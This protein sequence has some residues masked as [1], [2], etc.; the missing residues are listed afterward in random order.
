LSNPKN[1]LRINVG[2]FINQPN[3][4]YREIEFELPGIKLAADL[5]SGVIYGTVR[6]SRNSEGLLLQGD[7]QTQVNAECVRCL[8]DFSQ[9]L[10]TQFAELFYFH[11]PLYYHEQ[12]SDEDSDLIVPEDGYI[13]LAPLVREYLLLEY[14]INPLCRPDCKGL[15]PQCGENLNLVTCEHCAVPAAVKSLTPGS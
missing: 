10:H 14:P 7:F 4:T 5:R 13:D 3:G 1:P 2:F 12:D 15:C 6:I 9:T 11:K 8:D